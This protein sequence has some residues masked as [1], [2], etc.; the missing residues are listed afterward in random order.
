[1][2]ADVRLP[3]ADGDRSSQ[4]SL[5]SVGDTTP[6]RVPLVDLAGSPTSK[7]RQPSSV[8]S[9]RT[10]RRLDHTPDTRTDR[11]PVWVPSS[12]PTKLANGYHRGDGS[13]S[14]SLE[15]EL[16]PNPPSRDP[17]VYNG[18]LPHS[19]VAALQSQGH[20][21]VYLTHFLTVPTRC[22]CFALFVCKFIFDMT[23]NV[24]IG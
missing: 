17:T 12:A 1:M 9:R 23:C 21:P 7:R 22:P 13:L 2:P 16:S 5:Q 8:S 20:K 18:Q 11:S 19:R 4:E 10:P 6:R 15:T 14:R 24:L 3:I